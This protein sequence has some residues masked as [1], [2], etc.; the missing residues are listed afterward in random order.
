M[1]MCLELYYLV[2]SKKVQDLYAKAERE[3]MEFCPSVLK[4]DLI[5]ILALQKR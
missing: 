1:K 3:G 5:E 4:F 2:K